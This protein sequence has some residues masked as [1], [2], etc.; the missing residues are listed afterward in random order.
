MNYLGAIGAG[1]TT[2]QILNYVATSFP[3]LGHRIKDALASGKS[4]G[5]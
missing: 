2:Q 4:A 1:Y 3:E 5:I